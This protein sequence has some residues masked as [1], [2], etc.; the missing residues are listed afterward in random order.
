MPEK[1]TVSVT[2]E[3]VG[4]IDEVVAALEHGGMHVDQVLRPIGL[5]TGSIDTQ[6]VQALGD[7]AGVAA[8]ERQRTVQLPPPDSDVQ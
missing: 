5:I 8:V 2:D 7:V 3:A 4:R 1:V 6:R